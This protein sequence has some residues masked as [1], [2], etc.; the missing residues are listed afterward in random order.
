MGPSGNYAT[1]LFRSEHFF[2]LLRMGLTLFSGF[3][4]PVLAAA[5]FASA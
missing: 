2:A 3:L 1:K 5:T 4:A